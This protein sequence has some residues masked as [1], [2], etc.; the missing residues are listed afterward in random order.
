MISDSEPEEVEDCEEDKEEVILVKSESISESQDPRVEVQ[1]SRSVCELRKIVRDLD[2]LCCVCV[3][4]Y[5]Q[6][7]VQK[8]GVPAT[9]WYSN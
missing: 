9:S 6:V 1:N 4:A 3:R 2:Y 7:C 8:L 5:T